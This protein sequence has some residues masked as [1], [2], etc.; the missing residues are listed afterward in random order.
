M[1][2]NSP[3]QKILLVNDNAMILIVFEQMVEK[4]R[5]ELGKNL[6]ILRAKNGKEGLELF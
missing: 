5:K 2:R 3:N 1:M 4:A 6:I